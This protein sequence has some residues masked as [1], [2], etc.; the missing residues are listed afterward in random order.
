MSD[1]R[2]GLQEAGARRTQ[3][4]QLMKSVLIFLFVLVVAGSNF[5]LR[6]WSEE[7]SVLTYHAHADRS[8]NFVVPTLTWQRAASL[9]LDRGFQA[10]VSGQVY[11]QPLYW[12][13][14]DALVGMLLIATEDNVVYALDAQTGKEIWKRTLG[15][16]VARSS[17]H[18]GN[19]DP[20]GVTGTPVIDS[21]T[22][23][24]YLDAA[25]EGSSGPRHVVFA[26][27]LADGAPLPGWPIDVADKLQAQGLTFIP[28]D[29]NQR[30]ALTIVDGTLYVP[31]GGHYGDC[32]EYRGWVVGI[33]IEDPHKVISW[34]TRGIGGGIWAPGGISVGGHSLF[35]ATGNTIG[36]EKW[37]DGEAVIRLSA[38]L[39]RSDNK[40]DFFAPKDWHALDERDADLGGTNPLP[41]ELPTEGG[42]R[43]LVLALG[44]DGRAYLL[45]Q[46]DLGGIGGSLVVETVSNRPI[47]TAPI[48]YPG[49][50]GVFVA[51]QGEGA[52][53][54]K[55]PMGQWASDS[56]AG[57]VIRKLLKV[58]SNELT[59]LKI[60]NGSPATIETA[61]CGAL[62]G[63]GPPIVTTTDGHSN[64]V[65][66]ILGAEGDN[67]LHGFTGDTGE[68]LF[69]GGGNAEAMAGLQHFRTLIATDERLYVAADG[70]IYAFSF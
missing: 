41:L 35:V 25:V 62:S 6:A 24:I 8:G 54:Q 59:V 17:L 44:K 16:P 5:P 23:A 68:P 67:R 63:S 3:D 57:H 42:S 58:N 30:G 37:S 51:F 38:D 52:Q 65:V 27:S 47:R 13:P 29:Q 33:S 15:R 70:R 4:E 45:D 53:C 40:R 43:A 14:P 31:F 11:A 9:H 1:K 21:A 66:W 19:I 10:R 34:A 32:G 46:N 61:W 50:D 18:C 28:R 56:R 60:R 26:L 49:S 22:D 7:H 64:P 12:H 69:T 20:L 48:T 55:V 36:S 39:H 2:R